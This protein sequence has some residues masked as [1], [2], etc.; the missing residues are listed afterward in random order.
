ME[1][2]SVERCLGSI[3]RIK[4]PIAAATGSQCDC[5]W[6]DRKLRIYKEGGRG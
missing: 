4:L 3:N 1:G 6:E 5:I 2:L